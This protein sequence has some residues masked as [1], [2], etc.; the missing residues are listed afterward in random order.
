MSFITKENLNIWIRKLSQD[1]DV[2]IP[3]RKENHFEWM[4]FEEGREVDLEGYRPV[5]PLKYLF[6]SPQELLKEKGRKQR[7][8]FG[9][10]GCDLRG[11]K[12]LEKIYLE[13][14]IDPYYRKDNIIIGTDCTSFDENCFCDVLGD[15]PWNK[16]F[17]DLNLSPVEDGFVVEIGSERAKELI[18]K[19]SEFFKDVDDSKIERRDKNREELK[20]QLRE[21]NKNITF[22]LE[23]IKEKIEK[24]SG[25]FEKHGKKCV[26][27]SACTNICPACFCFFL[28][29][30][31]EGKARNMDS[32]QFPGYGRVAGGANPRKDLIKRFKHRF[33]CKFVYRPE[34]HGFKGCTGCGRCIDGCQGGIDWFDVL[35]EVHEST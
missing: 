19:F 28:S 18:K 35:R 27:C 11:L 8:I 23:E 6:Y 30:T 25:V 17:F 29:E 31:N 1:S 5:L 33:E 7:I 32:C 20:G 2:F 26:S 10:R 22:D 12:L 14:P 24:N 3:E 9:V 16:D 4:K 13:E 21:K 15:V 34:M